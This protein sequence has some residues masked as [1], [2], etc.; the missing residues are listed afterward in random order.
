MS[1]MSKQTCNSAEK[2]NLKTFN[3]WKGVI[4]EFVAMILFVYVGVGT[5]VYVT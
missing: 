2:P 3:F 5:A 4:A 1:I